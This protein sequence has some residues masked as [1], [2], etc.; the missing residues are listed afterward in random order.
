MNELFDRL[1][2]IQIITKTGKSYEFTDLHLSFTINKSLENNATCKIYN[3]NQTTR[4]ILTDNAITFRIYASYK[5]ENMDPILIFEGDIYFINHNFG[6]TDIITSIESIDG[7]N[8]INDNKVSVSY[9]NKITLKTLLNDIA[10]QLKLPLTIKT[11]AIN[12]LDKALNKGY[13]ANGSSKKILNEICKD[14][15]LNWSIQNGK[16]KILN[17]DGNDN[18]LIYNLNL[19]T[20]LIGSPEKIKIQKKDTGK[21]TNEKIIFG[22]KVRSLLIPKAEYGNLIQVSSREI[23]ANK[24]FKII[25]IVHNGDNYEDDFITELTLENIN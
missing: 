11:E 3:L 7:M 9:S 6:D 19:N 16:L 1:I 17:K 5:S 15:G 2:K 10:K 18:N 22:W 21:K 20:G 23:G 14:A 8:F 24:I 4:N 12:F 13:T 25:D